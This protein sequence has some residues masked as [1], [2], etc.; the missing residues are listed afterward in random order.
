MSN[1]K[2][3]PLMGIGGKIKDYATVDENDY[4]SLSVFRWFKNSRGYA[5][6]AGGRKN[7]KFYM[8]RVIVSPAEGLVVDHINGD[9]LDNRRSNLR[10]VTQNLN[11][12]N[13]TNLQNNNTSGVTGVGYWKT[14]S[15]WVARVTR[16]GKTKLLGYFKTKKEAVASRFAFN[17][18]EKACQS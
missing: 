1:T 11:C 16:N 7:H 14:G 12:Q 9:K 17:E 13:R 4:D 8:H 5:V 6:C 3:I 2:K 10:A 18:S 15:L